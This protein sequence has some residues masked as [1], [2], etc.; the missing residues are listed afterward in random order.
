MVDVSERL[1]E[2]SLEHDYPPQLSERE[3]RWVPA[4]GGGTARNILFSKETHS[5]LRNGTVLI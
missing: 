1:M 4:R 5:A 2:K 3:T